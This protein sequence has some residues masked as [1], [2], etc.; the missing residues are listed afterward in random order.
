MY[1]IKVGEHKTLIGL[2][3]ERY[4]GKNCKFIVGDITN[5]NTWN[6]LEKF[7]KVFAVAVIHHLP[8]KKE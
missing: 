6:D 5:E 4:G 2:A 8:S 3:R 7:D 1:I